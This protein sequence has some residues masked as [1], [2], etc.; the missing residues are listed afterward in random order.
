MNMKRFLKIAGLVLL[1]VLAVLVITGLITYKRTTDRIERRYASLGDEPGVL[2]VEGLAFRDLNKN[3]SLDVYEDHR[4][5]V[6]DRVDDLVSQMTLEEKAGAMYITMNGF[7][8][9]GTP[10]DAPFFSTDPMD[11]MAVMLLPTTS[12]MLVDKKMNSFNII[13]SSTAE[14]MARYNNN[15]QQLAERTRLG[16]PVTIATDPRHGAQNN[17]GA[18]LFTPAFSQWPSS[19]GL[20]ATRDT[21]LVR[22]FADIARKEYLAVGIRLALH[23]MADLATEPR[24]GRANGTF[25]EDADLAARM[26]RAY[27][28]GFQGDSLGAHSVACMTK[29]FSGGGPQEDGEDAH[30]EYGK[31]QVYPGDNFD[32]HL[33]PFEKGAFPAKTAQIMPYYGIPVDQT[34][35]DVA[36]AFNKTIITT[37]LR[38][39]YGFDGVI[40]TDW[41][42]ISGS[43]L[44]DARA[45]GVE[46]LSPLERTKK[47]LDAGCD[48]FGGEDSPELIIE[49]VESGQISEERLDVSVRRIM[50]DKFMLGLFDDPFVD[51]QMAEGIAG[52][53]RHRAMGKMAQ[54]KG[55]VLLKNEDL[56]PLQKGSKVYLEGINDSGSFD[57]LGEVVPNPEQADVIIKR[58]NTPFEERDDYFLEKFFHQ[59]RLYYTEEELSGLLDLTAQKPTLVVVNLERPAILTEVDAACTALMAE[60]GLEDGVLAKLVFGELAPEGKLP[61]ELPSSWEAVLEQKEDLPYDSEDPLYEFGHGLSYPQVPIGTK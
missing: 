42:I 22:A 35:E 12:E 52:T 58:I 57:G 45:W 48:Q 44:G 37:M 4:A 13:A 23:P 18:A 21:A 36:F 51:E 9:D 47:V 31:N 16:I 26:T 27:V 1:V 50:K 30:F 38:E 15:M 59:G 6:A 40:C 43:R 8:K 3:G 10:V 2:K 53:D 29:H 32:Y 60:F 55:T 46:N 14:A 56:L 41:N 5:S 28:L 33:I 25:G 7:R 17:P 61:F 24:W 11:I 54:A 20:A 39:E 19:L 34:G 49:L